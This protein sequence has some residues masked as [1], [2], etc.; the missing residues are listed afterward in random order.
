MKVSVNLISERLENAPEKFGFSVEVWFKICAHV[1]P[2]LYADPSKPD[3]PCGH[4]PGSE[5]KIEV[6]QKRFSGNR[7]LWNSKDSVHEE[8]KPEKSKMIRL[9][10]EEDE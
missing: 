7:L 9:D 4:P 3:Q 1:L 6:L 2:E 10:M 8:K 5:G